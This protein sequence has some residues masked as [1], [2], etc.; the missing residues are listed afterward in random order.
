MVSYHFSSEKEIGST[1]LKPAAISI[2]G[3]NAAQNFVFANENALYEVIEVDGKWQKNKIHEHQTSIFQFTSSSQRNEY[4]IMSHTLQNK[5]IYEFSFVYKGSR[6]CFESKSTQCNDFHT[7][8]D[9]L[10]GSEH[11]FIVKRKLG[12]LDMKN[13]FSMPVKASHELEIFQLS[14]CTSIGTYMISSDTPDELHYSCKIY[15]E[16]SFL[17]IVDKNANMLFFRDYH[18]KQAQQINF[19]RPILDG[20]FLEK[21][22]YFL[23][24]TESADKYFVGI[25]DTTV[26]I[27]ENK[28]IKQISLPSVK[29]RSL[30]LI[31]NEIHI[32]DK[33]GLHSLNL[34]RNHPPQ[35]RETGVFRNTL[36][37]LFGM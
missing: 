27:T 4:L 13:I 19:D 16:G 1:V 12:N 23:T 30:S 14:D 34:Q 18:E 26:S 29:P 28:D 36:Q 10:L 32:L 15:V 17:A 37:K 25:W 9:M 35:N 20:I 24:D 31:N 11:F 33:K 7:M 22:F 8:D 3:I 6:N 2:L 5:N 21:A